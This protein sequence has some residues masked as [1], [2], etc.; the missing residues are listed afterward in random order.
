MAKKKLITWMII[1]VIAAGIGYMVWNS[2]FKYSNYYVKQPFHWHASIE[3]EVCGEQRDL[4]RAPASTTQLHGGPFLGKSALRHTHDDNVYHTEGL[5]LKDKEETALGLFMDDIG[6]PFSETRIF[7]KRNGDVCENTD[8][9]GT[10]QMFV[11]GKPNTEFRDYVVEPT[12][13]ADDQVIRI[14]FG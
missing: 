1:L 2:G 5:R 12:P 10:V 8:S 9:A 13:K 14:V 11:N 4:P 7:E 3:I 6:V